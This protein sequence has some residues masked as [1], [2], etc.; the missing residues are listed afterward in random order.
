MKS[1]KSEINVK[2]LVR[3]KTIHL[4]EGSQA[5]PVFLSSKSNIKTK[6]NTDHWSNDTPKGKLN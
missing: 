4:L 5:L 6:T 3:S 1:F 2:T